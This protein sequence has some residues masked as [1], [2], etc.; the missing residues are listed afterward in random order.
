M[1]YRATCRAQ[2]SS[3]VKKSSLCS[4]PLHSPLPRGPKTA[5]APVRPICYTYQH[6]PN[7]EGAQIKRRGRNSPS[8]FPPQTSLQ[9]NKRPVLTDCRR[10]SIRTSARGCLGD[11]G[12][13]PMWSHRDLPKT[14][15]PVSSALSSVV[16]R[17]SLP[18]KQRNGA[19]KQE[20]HPLNPKRASQGH[21][22]TKGKNA[23]KR[24]FRVRAPPEGQ[25]TFRRPTVSRNTERA[26]LCPFAVGS[27][28]TVPL[29]P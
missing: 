13:G 28:G 22:P 2:W 14:D 18:R 7:G 9:T 19:E 4:L 15:N 29:A 6:Y 17:L 5:L 10:R 23:D 26:K 16:S 11:A 12:P 27:A 20:N 1:C 25:R 21:R 24:S 3:A 8:P